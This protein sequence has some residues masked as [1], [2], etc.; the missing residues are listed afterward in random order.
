M[1]PA[2]AMNQLNMERLRDAYTTYLPLPAKLEPHLEGALHH[3]LRNPGNLVRPQIVFQMS[4]AHGLPDVRAVELAI[5][6]EYFHTASL[7]FDDLP[8]MDHALERRGIPCVHIRFGESEAILAALAFINRAYALTWRAVAACPPERQSRA[9]AYLE[10]QLGVDGLLNGQS[11]DLH[12]ATLP[13][14]RE[15]TERIACGKTVSLIRL[16]IVL[17]ALLGS[18]PEGELRLLDRIAVYWGL[19]YQILDD[20]KDV[21]QSAAEPGKTPSRDGALDRP[22]IALAVGVPAAVARLTRLIYLGDRM[23]CRLLMAKPAVSFLEKLRND[24]Q[25]E[26]VHVTES[27]FEREVRGLA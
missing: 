5:A 20:L 14:D 27:A 11:L 13:H 12:Y 23:L 4:V 7:L 22:N 16:A 21:L 9:L 26:A 24:L 17:P 3:V 15:T 25:K 18:A 6:L 8:C 19:S 1:F 10:R 2:P